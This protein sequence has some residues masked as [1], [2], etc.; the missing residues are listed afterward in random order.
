M[1]EPIL[2]SDGIIEPPLGYFAAPPE[3]FRERGMLLILDEAQT[4]LYRTGAWYA[5]EGDGRCPE[6]TEH[7][8]PRDHNCKSDPGEPADMGP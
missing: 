3:K 6:K 4:G 7:F 5:F 8:G 2:S 1:A